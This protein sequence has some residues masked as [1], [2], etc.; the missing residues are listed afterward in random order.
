[1]A[2]IAAAFNVDRATLY[3]WAADYPDFSTA[4][5]RAKAYEQEWWENTGQK[6]LG[7]KHFQA[8]VWRTSMSARFKDDYTEAR[9][10]DVTVSLEGIVSALQQR[11]APKV[12]EGQATLKDDAHTQAQDVVGPNGRI[13]KATD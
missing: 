8:Q 3:K 11:E 13:D 7:A 9:N 2:V 4:L 1:M 5:A 12:V 10:V 6:K